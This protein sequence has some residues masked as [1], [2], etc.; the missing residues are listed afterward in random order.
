VGIHLLRVRQIIIRERKKYEKSRISPEQAEK[1]LKK[2]LHFMETEKPYLDPNISLHGLSEN[3]M[4]PDHYMSQII[5]TKLKLNFYD[6]IN[7]YRIEEAKR[8]FTNSKQE[9][10]TVLEVAYE[11][12][13][14]SKSAFNRAFKKTTHVTPSEFKKN[15][16]NLV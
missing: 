9:H 4:I 14:N 8:I 11:V 12:G 16:L 1:Y 5:N 7:N 2:L 15:H 13:F 10:L 6:F 3:L